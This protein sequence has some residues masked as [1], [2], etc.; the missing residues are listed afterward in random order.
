M[1]DLC[2]NAYSQSQIVE[3]ERCIVWSLGFDLTSPP[4][5][6][7][8]LTRFLASIKANDHLCKFSHYFA[9]RQ[10]QEYGIMVDAEVPPQRI[11]A[12]ALYLALRQQQQDTERRLTFTAGVALV[13]PPPHTFVDSG[14]GYDDSAVKTTGSSRSTKS[15]SISSSCS[16]SST[17]TLTRVVVPS[18]WTPLL[19]S[20][21]S[22][23]ERE[24]IDLA[25][26]MVAN[27]A[28]VMITKSKRRLDGLKRK[29]EDENP[30]AVN[31]FLPII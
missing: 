7:H 3:M 24:L 30:W 25:R 31:M 21:T 28:E 6:Y 2:E 26:N 17:M 14:G 19:V 16:R 15:G 27:V 10:L 9:E 11:A 29:W 20:L 18:P 8:F 13:S 5:V 22:F 1:V 12:A 23:K 4:T